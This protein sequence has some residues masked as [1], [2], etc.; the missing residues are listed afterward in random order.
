MYRLKEGTFSPRFGIDS[1]FL[2]VFFV[3]NKR[4]GTMDCWSLLGTN[5]SLIRR[6]L[7]LGRELLVKE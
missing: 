4:N 5:S 6:S 1:P 3:G 2:D 7:L